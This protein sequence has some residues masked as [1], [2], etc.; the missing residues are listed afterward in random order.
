MKPDDVACVGLI[1][2]DFFV[3]EIPWV[4]LVFGVRR[5]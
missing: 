1:T 5:D 3:I 4:A 2:T